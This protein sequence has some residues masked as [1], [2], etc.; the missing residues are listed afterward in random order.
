MRCEVCG[1]EIRGEPYR[2]VIEGGRLVVCG[3]CAQFSNKEWDPNRPAAKPGTRSRASTPAPRRRRNDI[4]QAEN[5]EL[6]ENYGEV[7]RKS[8]QRQGISI[9]DFAKK[10]SEKESV[11]KKLERG[12]SN[13]PMALVRKVSRELGVKVIDDTPTSTTSGVLMT[14]PRGARTLGDM[15]KFKESKD[16]EKED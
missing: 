16:E 4:E 5:Y 15:I 12:E 7:I 9:E 1:M 14:R 3:K 6:L 8:R 11:I 2:R 13:P 10:V